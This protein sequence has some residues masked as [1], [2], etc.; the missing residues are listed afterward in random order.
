MGSTPS[1]RLLD[2]GGGTGAF[3]SRF[4]GTFSEVVVLEPNDAVARV[5]ARRHSALRFVSGPGER[6]PFS[7]GSFHRLTAIRST[8]H[9]DSPERFFTEALR[10]LS[11]GGRILIEEMGPGSPLARMFNRLGHRGHHPGLDFRGPEAWGAGLSNAGFDEVRVLPDR[12]WFFLTGR[13][14]VIAPTATPP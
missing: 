1:E 4:A 11:A 12:R 14:P 8:H 2:V 13:K 6:I 3:T 10:V 9:M 5:G 7:D